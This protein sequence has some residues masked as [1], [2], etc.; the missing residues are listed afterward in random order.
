PLRHGNILFAVRN[1]A[2]GGYFREGE[3]HMAYLPMA[4]VGDFIFSVGAALVMRFSV[5]IPERPE[6]VLHDL[7]EVAPTPDFSSPRAWSAMLT[8]IQVGMSE[9]TRFKRWLYDRFMPFAVEL[10]RRRLEGHSPTLLERLRR[11]LGEILIY[12]PLRDRLG[13][14]RVQRAYTAGE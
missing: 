9:S 14:G 5:N 8:R 4:W 6:T 11:G 12:G 10:E 2:G 1:A 7:R 3:V 13:L